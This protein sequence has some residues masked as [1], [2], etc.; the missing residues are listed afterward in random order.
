MNYRLKIVCCVLACIFIQACSG[1]KKSGSDVDLKSQV[2]LTPELLELEKK[3]NEMNSVIHEADKHLAK[4]LVAFK[5]KLIRH[6]KK[7]CTGDRNTIPLDNKVCHAYRETVKLPDQPYVHHVENAIT[8]DKLQAHSTLLNNQISGKN[9]RS[10][11][12]NK[13]LMNY[14]CPRPDAQLQQAPADK[15]ISSIYPGT[16][17]VQRTLS[18]IW[19]GFKAHLYLPNV[20]KDGTKRDDL[21]AF[22]KTF[23]NEIVPIPKVFTEFNGTEQ[24]FTELE[25]DIIE[26]QKNPQA[27]TEEQQVAFFRSLEKMK[28][29]TAVKTLWATKEGIYADPLSYLIDQRVELESGS[30]EEEAMAWWNERMVPD[31][32]NFYPQ[33]LTGYYDMLKENYFPRFDER[34]SIDLLSEL[35]M[36]QDDPD[37]P[38]WDPDKPET[39]LYKLIRTD[40]AVGSFIEYYNKKWFGSSE[41]DKR[42]LPLNINFIGQVQLSIEALKRLVPTLAQ[43]NP[44][45]PD[46][47]VK[48]NKILGELPYQF[49]EH[50]RHMRFDYDSKEINKLYAEAAKKIATMPTQ[51]NTIDKELLRVGSATSDIVHGNSRDMLASRGTEIRKSINE[52]YTLVTGQKYEDVPIDTHKE[53]LLTDRWS[54][55]DLLDENKRRDYVTIQFTN[56]LSSVITEIDQLYINY[57]FASELFTPEVSAH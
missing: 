21:I 47:E 39:G 44:D 18:R 28:Y 26:M 31:A 15:P 40:N 5:K 45:N 17:A 22:C 27:M 13:A 52:I 49:A 43:A 33:V 29:H 6:H 36:K 11:A 57:V 25:A 51:T 35:W 2:Q 7:G 30:N 3:I 50:T 14:L 24:E 16:N 38:Y 48:L 32:L 37:I 54:Y 41:F 42:V 9:S 53:L 55:I 19:P 23:R 8:R 20:L 34:S 1:D 46:L 4:E 10:S 56:H 12:L